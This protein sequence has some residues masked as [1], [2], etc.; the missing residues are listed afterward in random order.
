MA[1]ISKKK[2]KSILSFSIPFVLIPG[3]FRDYLRYIKHSGVMGGKNQDKLTGHIIASYHVVEKGLTMPE[4]RLGFGRE[5]LEYLINLCKIFIRKYGKEDF[6]VMHAISVVLE[7]KEFHKEHN[8]AL[9]TTLLDKI[10][11]LAS[12]VEDVSPNHQQIVTNEN[13]FSEVNSSFD[14]FSES[15][16]SIRNYTNEDIPLET[17]KAAVKLAQNAP[18]ACNRQ[19]VKVHVVSEPDKVQEVLRLQAAN[20]GFG[21]LANKAIIVTCELGVFHGLRERNAGFVDGGLLAMNLLYAL[22]YYKIAA[23]TLNCSLSIKTEKKIK[24]ICNIKESESLVLMIC[25]GIPPQ[26]F[27]FASS[28][29]YPVDHILSIN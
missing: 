6:Q 8:Y 23:C 18:S 3:F 2:L 21:H 13:Y 1:F 10:K 22:H 9:D 11:E 16:K 24:K 15:R 26:E 14:K 5:N 17:I 27:N 19:T 20:R 25:C 7:Y 4:T 29:R 12:M 28:T